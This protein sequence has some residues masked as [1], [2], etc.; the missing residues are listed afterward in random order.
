MIQVRIPKRNKEI[1]NLYA[2]GNIISYNDLKENGKRFCFT[3]IV[4]LQYKYYKQP[5]F[6]RAYIVTNKESDNLIKM[7]LPNVKEP[8]HIIYCIDGG[9]RID[10]LRQVIYNLE[11]MG[12]KKIYEFPVIFWQKISCLLDSYN[13]HTSNAIKSNLMVL[14]QQYQGVKK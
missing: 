4:I 2:N 13:G 3:N 11:Q 7:Y 6:R 10:L 8:V 12:E 9:R 5:H 1:F 14:Y